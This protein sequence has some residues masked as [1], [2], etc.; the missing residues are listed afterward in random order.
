MTPGCSPRV[1][2]ARYDASR[3]CSDDL[4]GDDDQQEQQPGRE[5]AE[6]KTG[7][8]QDPGHEDAADVRDEPCREHEHRQW[9]GERHADQGQNDEA[10]HGVHGRDDGGSAHVAARP[11]HCLL[12]G[13]PDPV[14]LPAAK[15]REPDIPGLAAVQEQIERQEQPEHHDSP[16]FDK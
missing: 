8:Q 2:S 10:H 16:G 6:R 3:R 9:P 12:A 4:Q 14:A 7:Q 1:R 15:P 5:P 11:A 13:V